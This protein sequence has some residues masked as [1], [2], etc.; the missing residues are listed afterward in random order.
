ME[1][2]DF[3]LALFGSPGQFEVGAIQRVLQS[4]AHLC[5]GTPDDLHPCN[6]PDIMLLAAIVS[7]LHYL[8]KAMLSAV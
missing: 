8:H 2:L 5:I 6:N 4:A 1:L 3:G 7:A